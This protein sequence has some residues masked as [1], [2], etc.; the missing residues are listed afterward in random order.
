MLRT[1]T[2]RKVLLIGLLTFL[3][4]SQTGPVSAESYAWTSHGPYGGVIRALA[5]NPAAPSTLYA[6]TN[7]AGTGGGVFKSTN[8]GASWSAVNSGLTETKVWALA[9]NPTTTSTL[10]VATNYGGVFKSTNAG[11]SWSAANTGIPQFS[12]DTVRALGD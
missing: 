6:G 8:G 2:L 9:I 1:T 5:I 12:D 3:I 10:Y 4:A 11:A 7:V